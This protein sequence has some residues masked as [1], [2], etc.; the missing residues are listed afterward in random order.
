MGRGFGSSIRH[1]LTGRLLCSFVFF[2]FLIS[3]LIATDA[4]GSVDVNMDPSS[5]TYLAVSLN[6]DM[7]T[8]DRSGFF[9]ILAALLGISGTF[10]LVPIK[11]P[12]P[13][14]F[15]TLA[16]S[17]SAG[18]ALLSWLVFSLEVSQNVHYCSNVSIQG[19]PAVIIGRFANAWLLAVTVCILFPAVDI[20]HVNNSSLFA[21]DCVSCRWLDLLVFNW[22]DCDCLVLG[23]DSR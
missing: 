20:I 21:S 22:P 9:V 10:N 19:I 4:F 11:R 12:I 23:Y 2:A 17:Y 7:L 1:L 15:F 13:R 16:F 18:R 14:L 5:T 6:P 8:A 3:I